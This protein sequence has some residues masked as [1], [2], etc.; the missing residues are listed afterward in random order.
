MCSGISTTSEVKAPQPRLTVGSTTTDS[1]GDL[2]KTLNLVGFSIENVASDG[3]CMYEAIAR[4]LTR[5]GQFTTWMDVKK[6]ILDFIGLN[7]CVTVS[8]VSKNIV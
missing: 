2:R 4:Q 7:P 8:I 1:I 6:D 3:N 5:L